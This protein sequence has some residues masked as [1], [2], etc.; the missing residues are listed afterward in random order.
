MSG[1]AEV[2]SRGKIKLSAPIS[3]FISKKR[4]H[5]IGDKWV[6]SASGETFEVFNPSTGEVIAHAAAGNKE[7]I[8]RA[9]KAAKHSFNN[10]PWMKM[11]PADRQRIIWKIGDLLMEHA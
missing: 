3:S 6:D 10:G 8:D 11:R 7:D 4:Q 9:V 5:L 1:D 2:L